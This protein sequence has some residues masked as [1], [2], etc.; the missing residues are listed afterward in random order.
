MSSLYVGA[1]E[2]YWE[3]EGFPRSEAVTPRQ[4]GTRQQTF[5]AYE[6][7]VDW[8]HE[9]HARR[10]LR[11]F[12]SLLR[13]LDRESRKFGSDGLE[14]SVL[15]EL[16]E[17]FDR[18]G[19]Q[20]DDKLRIRSRLGAAGPP[21]QEA[22]VPHDARNITQVT[23][24]RLFRQLVD[25]GVKWYGD[26]DEIDFLRRLYELE[27]LPSEDIRF[28]NAEEDIR[29]HRY[30]NYDWEE[31]WIYNDDRFGL[32]DGTDE[33]LLRFLA[34]MLHPEVRS[35]EA[36]VA[37]L[38]EHIDEAVRRDGYAFVPVADI[39]GYPI[40]GARG[41][42]GA[43]SGHSDAESRRSAEADRRGL[44]VQQVTDVFWGLPEADRDAVGSFAATSRT[45][46]GEEAA[47]EDT[48][49]GDL[50]APRGEYAAVQS[51]ARGHR[52]D[53][54]MDR[55][56]MKEGGQA[57]IFAATHKA[58]G[59]RVALKRRRS[60]RETPAARMR[61]EIEV[62]QDL[63]PHP[64]YVPILDA[65][66]SE[67][68]LIMPM[69]QG[70]AEDHRDRLQN[71]AALLDLVNALID[72]LHA[73]HTHGW[74]HRDVKPSNILLLDDRWRLGDWGVVRRPRGQTTKADRTRTEVGTDG[75]AAPELFIDAHQATAAADI[76]GVGRVIAWA[77][78]DEHP[79][80]NVPL[81]PAPGPWRNIVRRATARDPR[82]RPQTAAELR[83][84]VQDQ[85]A[86]PELPTREEA[87]RLLALA[88][89][90]SRESLEA[91][92]SLIADHPEDPDLYIDTLTQ[93][94]PETAAEV[95]IELPADAARLLEAMSNHASTP[96]RR[97]QFAEANRATLWLQRVSAFAASRG[98]WN[99]L[100]E[101]ARTMCTWDAIWNQYRAQDRIAAWLRTLQ[102]EPALLLAGAFEEHPDCAKHFAGL[103][104]LTDLDPKIGKAI[105][106]ATNA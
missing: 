75:F 19:Y 78:T 100:D 40:Y 49:A 89:T 67:G 34:E 96:R 3:N 87:E 51:A 18:D 50:P 22:G 54:A 88:L 31:D 65:N 90:G 38:A 21:R 62:A 32:R 74:L 92:L 63:N 15:E 33:V 59:V 102:G 7:S 106:K 36:E 60:H 26:V 79:E 14:P 10:A 24:K 105:W 23:R 85:L 101:A 83:Q 64:H 56:R 81:L 66:P 16:R 93:L 77:L 98:A 9:E 97:N 30:N 55:V 37:H 48:Q 1:I 58:T 69:A 46:S 6:A 72:V 35:D 39:S 73:A 11:V 99:L 13:R 76:Y 94:K 8:G 68:W 43:D 27:A 82:N 42:A 12:E 4:G 17:A 53:Y 84:L 104:G 20:L 91:F 70:T 80:M 2:E 47:E 41:L 5:D 28:S 71:P 103:L 57:D 86:E 52:K 45:R 25:K 95:L 61:R 29:Q 44:P